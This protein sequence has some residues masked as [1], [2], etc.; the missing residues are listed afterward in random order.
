[1]R[2]A[3]NLG[4]VPLKTRVYFILTEKGLPTHN[5]KYVRGDD[6]FEIL[7]TISRLDV[8]LWQVSED[9]VT[10]LNHI[11]PFLPNATV[12]APATSED[13]LPPWFIELKMHFPTLLYQNFEKELDDWRVALAIADEQKEQVGTTSGRVLREPKSHR[14]PITREGKVPADLLPPTEDDDF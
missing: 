9:M 12:V 7:S 1:M 6:L 5:L 10:S 14:A 8:V 13:P 2:T 3:S 11:S 4:K